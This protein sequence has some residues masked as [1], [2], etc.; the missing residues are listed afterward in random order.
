MAYRI[1]KDRTAWWPVTWKGVA[2]DGSLV[3]NR[4]ELR[5]RVMKV[6]E[7]AA[8][9]AAVQGAAEAEEQPGARLAALWA[10]LV[11]QMAT[12]WR[13][14]EQENGEPLRWD[15]PAG[16]YVDRDEAGAVKPLTAPNLELLLNEPGMFRHIFDAF[17]DCINARERLREGN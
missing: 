2:E 16:W 1:V 6:D 13:G 9:I 8:M 14:L 7:A 11:A 15:V 4:I 10:S 3:D 17:R 5:F 12:D